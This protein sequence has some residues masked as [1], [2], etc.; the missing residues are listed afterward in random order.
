MK[1]FTI[2]K[3]TCTGKDLGYIAGGA[4]V[5][6]L[7][8]LSLAGGFAAQRSGNIVVGWLGYSVGLILIITA[9]MLIHM[10]MYNGCSVHDVMSRGHG[11]DAMKSNG[12]GKRK[13]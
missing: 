13:K 1:S 10:G 5:G 11:M 2:G 6:G 8:L 3:C 12:K 7:A 4:G 9:K